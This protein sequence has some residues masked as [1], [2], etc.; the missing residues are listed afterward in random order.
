MV[1]S[2][3]VKL[4]GRADDMLI[5]GGVKGSP[6]PLEERLRTDPRIKDAAMVG[7]KASDGGDLVCVALV[8]SDD[9]DTTE[10]SANIGRQF[11]D[12]YRAKALFAVMDDLPRTDNGKVSRAKVRELFRK[13]Q[14]AAQA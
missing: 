13:Q 14:E 1:G 5:L 6:L 9:A 8:P 11:W 7:I 2:R 4:L 10:I 3:K 12:K